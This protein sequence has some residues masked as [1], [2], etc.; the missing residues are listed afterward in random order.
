[1][2]TN[3]GDD[4]RTTP[5]I[6]APQHTPRASPPW[7]RLAKDFFGSEKSCGASSAS[8]RSELLTPSGGRMV[9]AETSSDSDSAEG[10]FSGSKGGSG[11][12]VVLSLVEHLEVEPPTTLSLGSQH[13]HSGNCTPC[14]FFRGRR[15]CREGANCNLCHFPHEEMTY[16][17]IRRAVRIAGVD[18]SRKL[19]QVASLKEGAA[20]QQGSASRDG[21]GEEQA[22]DAREGTP[23]SICSSSCSCSSSSGRKLRLAIALPPSPP[24]PPLPMPSSCAEEDLTGPISI[25]LSSLSANYGCC[26]RPAP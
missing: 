21:A 1:M 5:A 12:A 6:P 23:S 4:A 24:L 3:L 9:A 19:M 14:K 13:H 20:E 18:N 15:G 26:C 10:S 7:P 17:A 2:Y 11:T 22:H 16:S 8:T 25:C